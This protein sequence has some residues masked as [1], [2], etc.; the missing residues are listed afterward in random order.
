MKRVLLFV[1]AAALTGCSSSLEVAHDYDQGAAFASYKTYSWSERK[2]TAVSSLWDSRIRKAVEAQL[3]AKGLSRTETNADLKVVY[4]A[5]LG[6]QKQY[7]TVVTGGYGYGW[8]GARMGG[9]MATTT[10]TTIPKGALVVDLVDV[11]RNELVWRARATATV[12]PDRKPEEAEATLGKAV[13][14]MFEAY[15]PPAN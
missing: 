11:R 10:E 6:A 14:K 2:E 9:S 3:A 12:D 4:V 5:G 15:P 13:A 8:R 1:L 7:N